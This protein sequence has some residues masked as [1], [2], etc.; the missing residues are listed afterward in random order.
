MRILA[1][2][3]AQ[4]R[5]PLWL[6]ALWRL[7]LINRSITQFI[8]SSYCVLFI[9]PHLQ[10]NQPYHLIASEEDSLVIDWP[11]TVW[12]THF[13]FRPVVVLLFAEYFEVRWANFGIVKNIEYTHESTKPIAY[14]VQ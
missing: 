8:I 13:L 5:K 4:K 7:Y 9:F 6:I 3:M 2:D 12:N 11:I 14:E 1:C 10:L